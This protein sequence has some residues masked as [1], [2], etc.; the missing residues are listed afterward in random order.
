[1]PMI[2]L[3]LLFSFMTHADPKGFHGML[4]FGKESVYVSHL[5]MFH[6]PHDYQAIVKVRLDPDSEAKYLELAQT[7]K[8]IFTFAPSGLFVLPDVIKFKTPIKGTLFFGHFERGGKEIMDVELELETVI[9]FKKLTS[10][11]A[12]DKYL[13]FGSNKESFA[14]HLI[15]AKP[16]LD[17]F[18]E[19]DPS[20]SNAIVPRKSLRGKV[21][22]QETQDLQ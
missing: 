3:A 15:D 14:A 1:M 7:H 17:E 22:Y 10:G 16:G 8:G 2:I 19:I 4:V 12:Q 9:L 6:N 20:Q 18:W 5:P 21:F 11:V 13:I